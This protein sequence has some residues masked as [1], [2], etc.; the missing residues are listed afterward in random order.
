M[1]QEG[2]IADLHQ[3]F[4]ALRDGEK[5]EQLAQLALAIEAAGFSLKIHSRLRA[6]EATRAATS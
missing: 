5:P 3:V 2:I 4:H 6:V 1:P